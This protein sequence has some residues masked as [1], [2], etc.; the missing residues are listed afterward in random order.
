[1][2]EQVMAQVFPMG[3]ASDQA[4]RMAALFD[5]HYN[6]LYRLA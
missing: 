1:M 2:N 6:R 3:S 5:T 4:G